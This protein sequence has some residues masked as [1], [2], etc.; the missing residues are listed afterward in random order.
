MTNSNDNDQYDHSV[1]A[2]DDPV[3]MSVVGNY[4]ARQVGGDVLDE[5]IEPPS[6][7]INERTFINFVVNYYRQPT[8]DNRLR[9][10]NLVKSPNAVIKVVDNADTKKL[11]FVFPSVF[12]KINAMSKLKDHA[13]MSSIEKLVHEADAIRRRAGVLGEVALAA[14]AKEMVYNTDEEATNFQIIEILK[15]YGVDISPDQSSDVKTEETKSNTN[16]KN[17]DTGYIDEW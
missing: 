17:D 16:T 14:G 10:L 9:L 7:T 1:F 5:L 15:R 13:S 4:A 3:S 12:C 2:T 11:L 8:D 6:V